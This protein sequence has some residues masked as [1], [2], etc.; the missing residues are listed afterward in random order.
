MDPAILGPACS[1]VFPQI[2][3]S[4][5]R[6]RH[7]AGGRGARAGYDIAVAVASCAI[8]MTVCSL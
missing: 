5:V 7:L 3:F 1:L 2:C 6:V 4:G 8:G